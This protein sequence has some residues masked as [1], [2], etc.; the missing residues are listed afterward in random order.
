MPRIARNAPGGMVFHVLNRRVDCQPLFRRDADY[1]RFEEVLGEVSALVPIRICAF[2]LMP[3]HWHLVLWPLCDGQLSKFMHRVTVTHAVRWK[4]HNDTV[5]Q[6]HLYQ[7]RFKSFPV[8]S[9]DHYLT[10]VRYVERN[11]LRAKLVE[12][13]EEWRFSSLWRRRARAVTED[14]LLSSG[15][16]DLPDDWHDYVNRPET[17]GELEALR[18]S[19]RRGNPFGT[20]TWQKQTARKLGLESTYRRPGRPKK[21]TR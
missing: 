21:S 6:G 18:R 4:G 13:A 10:V 20:E 14:P 2:C 9:D 16:V 5:G 7:N 3:N 11:A 15:P 12:R 1:L 8:Q 19:A 17:E